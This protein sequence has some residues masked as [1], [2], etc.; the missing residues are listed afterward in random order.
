VEFTLPEAAADLERSDLLPALLKSGPKVYCY[1]NSFTAI[2]LLWQAPI[3][4]L[5]SVALRECPAVAQFCL[6][7]KEKEMTPIQQEEVDVIVREFEDKYAAAFRSKDAK[8]L[9]ELLVR[10]VTLLS[11]WGDVMQGRANIERMLAGVFP[12]MPDE[13]KLVNTP[14]HSRAITEDVILSHGSS[15]KIGDWSTGEEKLSYTRVLVRRG[16]EWKLAATQVAPS[17]SMPDPRTSHTAE[18]SG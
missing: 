11:E 8:A 14:A 1:L 5:A 13:L 2:A 15:H 4:F 9:S 16:G 7:V 10:E 6:F 3:R 12:N 17:S 18:G